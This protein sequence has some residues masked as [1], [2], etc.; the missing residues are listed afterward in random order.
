MAGMNR[1]QVT[2]NTGSGGP[3]LSTFYLDNAV[4]DV[5]A[6]TAFFTAL[7]PYAPPVVTWSIP[8]SGDQ[9]DESNGHLVGSWTGTGGGSMT[10]TGGTAYAAGTGLFIRWNT[11]LIVG[12]RRLKGRTFF[13]P[14]SSANYDTNGTI[15]DSVVTAIQTAASN[16]VVNADCKIWHRPTAALPSSGQTSVVT[17]AVVVDRVTSLRSRRF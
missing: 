4:T 7:K 9:I 6:L 5:S 8:S 15:A 17:S 14:L 12:T 3:G 13:C 10:A 16:L 11:P 2:W 1:I